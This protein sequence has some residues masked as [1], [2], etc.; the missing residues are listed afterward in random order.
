[1]NPKITNNYY[2][3]LDDRDDEDD[4]DR[5]Q[6]KAPTSHHWANHYATHTALTASHTLHHNSALSDSGA[7]SHFLSTGA[8]VVNKKVDNDPL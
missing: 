2:A 4:H 6:D 1:M 7:T 5:P 3:L 8:N